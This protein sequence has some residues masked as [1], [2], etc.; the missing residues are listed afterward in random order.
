MADW[1]ANIIEEFRSNE[2]RV[3]GPFENQPLLLLHHRGAKS[4]QERV[5]PLAFQKLDN[6][7]AIFASKGGHPTNPDWYSNLI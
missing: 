1:N 5:N 2:G 7:Y 6:G 4:G 3:G